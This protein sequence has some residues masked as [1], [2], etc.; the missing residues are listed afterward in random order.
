MDIVA[1]FDLLDHF[2]DP[3]AH[4]QALAR[5]MKPTGHLVLGVSNIENCVGMLH[6]H[7]LRRD[8][9]VGLT[10]RSLR[11]ACTAAGLDAWI[12]DDG[13]TM[14]AVC[15]RG[16]VAPEA[17]VPGE[18][19]AVALALTENDGRLLLKR[20]LA[21]HGPTD[22]ALRVAGVAARGCRTPRCYAELCRDVAAACERGGRI[23]LAAQWLGHA[24]LGRSSQ[25]VA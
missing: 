4:L 7:R 9:P 8:A 14:F 24:E 22:A 21:E 11:A 12:W 2:A 18:A 13:A 1:E 17:A 6:P 3:V 15:E 25:N 23:E 20:V 10:R 16:D 5:L 19:A